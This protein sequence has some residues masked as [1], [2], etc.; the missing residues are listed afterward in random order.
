MMHDRHADPRRVAALAN[1]AAAAAARRRARAWKE[2]RMSSQPPPPWTH[3]L[4]RDYL[5]YHRLD[6][7]HPAAP[8]ALELFVELACHPHD[9]RLATV[10]LANALLACERDDIVRLAAAVAANHSA[11]TTDAIFRRARLI[12][13]TADPATEPDTLN[14]PPE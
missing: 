5:S 13:R 4:D 1:A 10:V 11:P 6:D 8:Y 3:L 14:P 7:T 9:P 2:P 12:A